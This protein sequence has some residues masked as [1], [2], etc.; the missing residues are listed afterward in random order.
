M[1]TEECAFKCQKRLILIHD[2]FNQLDFEGVRVKVRDL[3]IEIKSLNFS[4][5]LNEEIEKAGCAVLKLKLG[6]LRNKDYAHSCPKVLK[7][8]QTLIE[9]LL[10]KERELLNGQEEDEAIVEDL[11]TE[12]HNNDDNCDD[13]CD[14]NRDDNCDD[15]R[16]IIAPQIDKPSYKS[17][18]ETINGH[19]YPR[20]ANNMQPMTVFNIKWK[21]Y[22]ITRQE[23]IEI[24]LQADNGPQKMTEYLINCSSRSRNTLIN[25]NPML[26]EL[27]KV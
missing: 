23:T 2:E 14:D 21:K 10:E 3:L 5:D 11:E 26:F 25:R 1:E 7:D 17:E 16:D 19:S 22:K 6:K 20:K 27:L 15:N 24:V 4:Q 13:N 9:A 12:P 18:I 8:I